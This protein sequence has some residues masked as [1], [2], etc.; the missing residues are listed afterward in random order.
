MEAR[1]Q[2]SGEKPAAEGIFDTQRHQQEIDRAENIA[3]GLPEDAMDRSQMAAEE[4]HKKD[5][6]Q[7]NLSAPEEVHEPSEET[8]RAEGR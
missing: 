1:E 6:R 5:Y 8:Y 4:S 3:A 2:I 7:P